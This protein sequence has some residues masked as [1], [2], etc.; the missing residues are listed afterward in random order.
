MELRAERAGD[1]PGISELH[2]QAFPSA[3]EVRLVDR[4]RQT[5]A[6]CASTVAVAHGRIVGHALFSRASIVFRDRSV[7]IAALGPVAVMPAQQRQGVGSAV[8]GHG[9]QR[10]WELGFPAAIVLGSPKFYGRFGFARADAWEV[11]CELAVPAE[12]FLI[13]WAGAPRRGPAVAKYDPAFAV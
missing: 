10:C 9:L 8:V 1:Q 11:T 12:A 13:A 3:E 5:G 2:G 4:L 7:E 6:I